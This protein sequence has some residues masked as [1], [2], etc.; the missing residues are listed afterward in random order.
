MKFMILLLTVTTASANFKSCS[1]DKI[2]KCNT[3]ENILVWDSKKK[4][5]WKD[6]NGM[7]EKDSKYAAKSAI[8]LKADYTIKKDILTKFNVCCLFFK[9][10]AWATITKEYNLN[11]E[12]KH[13]DIGEIHAR[14]LRRELTNF[15]K[16]KKYATTKIIDSIYRIFYKDITICKLN[17][18]NKPVIHFIMMDRKSGMQK[19]K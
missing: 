10:K 17:T 7:P 15:G 6:F 8:T 2:E 3:D 1:K 9:N 11:H 5:I 18:M 12:Q 14:L 19:S 4:L 13:F 16:E